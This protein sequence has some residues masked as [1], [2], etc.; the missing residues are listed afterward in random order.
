MVGVQSVGNR[1][2]R[3]AKLW[4]EA[5]PQEHSK[6]RGEWAELMFM[7]KARREGLIVAKPFG[8][9][10]RYDVLVEYRGRVWRVQVKST[11]HDRGHGHYALNIM[12]PK[13]QPYRKGEVDFFA[14]YL[15]PIDT[16]YIIPFEAAGQWHRSLRFT[17]A[18]KRHKYRP[19]RE[20]WRLL[21]RQPRGRGSWV[22]PPDPV[23]I[24]PKRRRVPAAMGTAVAP[25]PSAA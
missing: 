15:I 25:F 16:W 18:C 17:V 12:G 11:M 24:L 20:A 7:A 4:D 9:T 8:D 19:F 14:I 2:G 3:S 10:A 21:K 22:C 13:R 23:P 6:E 1:E 5:N